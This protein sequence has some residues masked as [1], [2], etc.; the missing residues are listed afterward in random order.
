MI[1]KRPPHRLHIVERQHD[2]L[3]GEL[4]RHTGAIRLAKR[5]R[6]RAGL[7]Q[8][9]V[10]VT[11]VT[12]LELD[13]FVALGEATRQADRRHR[14]LGAGVAH[15]HLL[16]RRH[17]VDDQLRHADLERIRDAKTRPMLGGVLHRLDNHP[18]G[19]PQNRRP[20]SAHI[21]DVLVI[22]GVPNRGTA[23]AH[24][25]KRIAADSAK[26]PHGGIHPARNP[27]LRLFKKSL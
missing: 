18:R 5:Q 12:A 14:R 10:N 15:P 21:I 1:S 25:E 9:R 11:M 16:H 24:G 7:D 26:S 6:A 8:Q 4:G 19:V 27:L 3:A 2:R 17:C 22:V 20:P 23:G 13:Y